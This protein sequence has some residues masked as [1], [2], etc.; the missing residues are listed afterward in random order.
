MNHGQSP[1]DCFC[2]SKEKHWIISVT[3]HFWKAWHWFLHPCSLLHVA[4]STAVS[5]RHKEFKF[6]QSVFWKTRLPLILEA[7][8]SFTQDISILSMYRQIILR[9]WNICVYVYWPTANFIIL[10][11]K[12]LLLNILMLHPRKLGMGGTAYFLASSHLWKQEILPLCLQ[13]LSPSLQRTQL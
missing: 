2:G 11:Y 4:L 12:I 10:L 6:I 1:S 7:W 13:C 9:Q 3:T 5:K 8:D